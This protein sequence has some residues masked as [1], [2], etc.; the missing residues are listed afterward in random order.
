MN[1]LNLY[2]LSLILSLTFSV[3]G[4]FSKIMHQ[5]IAS[6]L[7]PIGILISL[8]Y[9]VIGVYD[10]FM[11]AKNASLVKIMWLVGF[12]CLSWIVG[13]LYYPHLKKNSYNQ[14]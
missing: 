4:A 6:A 13:L 5:P 14:N 1:K 7:L 11:D 10:S 8:I 2:K 9:I 3:V 12:I